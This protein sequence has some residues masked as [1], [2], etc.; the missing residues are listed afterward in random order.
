[1]TKKPL[2]QPIFDEDRD[3]EET[4]DDIYTCKSNH[5][6]NDHRYREMNGDYQNGNVVRKLHHGA[7]DGH[8][9][10][11]YAKINNVGYENGVIEDGDDS[12]ENSNIGDDWDNYNDVGNRQDDDKDGIIDDA[13]ENDGDDQEE[14]WNNNNKSPLDYDNDVYAQLREDN[15]HERKTMAHTESPPKDIFGTRNESSD[16]LSS[17]NND[18]THSASHWAWCKR[19]MQRWWR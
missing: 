17:T 5:H 9:N 4:L 8:N 19:H 12:D 2:H 14:N 7:S 15:G 11:D 6:S 16:R 18:S 1:M 10:D 3:N 13:M